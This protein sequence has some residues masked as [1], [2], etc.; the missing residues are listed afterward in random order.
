MQ[1]STAPFL[2]TK[3]SQNTMH[4]PRLV[5]NIPSIGPFGVVGKSQASRDATKPWEIPNNSLRVWDHA[6][7][8]FS[9]RGSFRF[10][11]R[12]LTSGMAQ[13]LPSGD[14]SDSTHGQAHLPQ[15]VA[16]PSAHTSDGMNLDAGFSP[17]AASTD[18]DCLCNSQAKVAM[19]QGVVG[20]WFLCQRHG[21]DENDASEKL[22]STCCLMTVLD[23]PPWGFLVFSWL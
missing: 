11:L 12:S 23:A 4:R 16:S 1:I 2:E 3:T 15:L 17:H 19:L 13:T 5:E 9:L 21:K 18:L 8:R 20:T 6:W 10:S 14:N 7:I 22:P